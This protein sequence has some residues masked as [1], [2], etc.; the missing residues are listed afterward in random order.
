MQKQ[1]YSIE[2]EE[3]TESHSESNGKSKI[4]QEILDAYKCTPEQSLS[5]QHESSIAS[6]E[7]KIEHSDSMVSF[8]ETNSV[9]M[10]KNISNEKI[11]IFKRGRLDSNSESNPSNEIPKNL[12]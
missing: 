9:G 6:N 12:K 3:K 7:E 5:M 4:T 11:V 2:L 1:T 8:G 10:N